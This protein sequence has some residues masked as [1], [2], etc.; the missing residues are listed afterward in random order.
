MGTIGVHN[1]AINATCVKAGLLRKICA[2]LHRCWSRPLHFSL[3]VF[4]H[5]PQQILHLAH[6]SNTGDC[7]HIQW[8]LNICLVEW[9]YHVHV[10][11]EHGIVVL[12]LTI[13][14]SSHF[15]PFCYRRCSWRNRGVIWELWRFEASR[16]ILQFLLFWYRSS[17]WRI[18]GLIWN[19]WSFG[20]TRAISH[21]P[22]LWYRSCNW[23]I[24]GLIWDCWR[25]GATGHLQNC[26]HVE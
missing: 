5:Q 13:K 11:R 3:I 18:R 17:N 4:F 23:R 19:T 12:H 25:F 16:V 22:P 21:F 7:W 1:A 8:Y 15:L 10:Q 14:D 24:R 26:M 6:L 20:A 2:D 9:K